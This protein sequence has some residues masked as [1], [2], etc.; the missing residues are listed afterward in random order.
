MNTG[1]SAM[2]RRAE[3]FNPYQILKNNPQ[4]ELA[5]RDDLEP[6]LWSVYSRRGNDAVF[7]VNSSLTQVQR[8]C[9]IAHD[10]GHYFLAHDGC[11]FTENDK[12]LIRLGKQEHDAWVWAADRLIDKYE[13]D[14]FMR[15]DS[16]FGLDDALDYFW[17]IKEVLFFKLQHSCLMQAGD[18]C[19]PHIK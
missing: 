6:Y 4:I 14:R 5:F 13:L 15:M 18:L 7:F 8:R 9:V 12:D 1:K 10:L 11:Y 19:L 17:V 2:A 3:P 16:Q